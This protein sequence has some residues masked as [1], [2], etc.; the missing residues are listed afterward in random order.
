MHCNTHCVSYTMLHTAKCD[1]D[2]YTYNCVRTYKRTYNLHCINL[3]QLGA[4]NCALQLK[5]VWIHSNSSLV[6][7]SKGKVGL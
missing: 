6:S 1:Y 7:M 2:Y 4:R 3:C 5:C